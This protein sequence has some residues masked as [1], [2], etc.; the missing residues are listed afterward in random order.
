[1]FGAPNYA[2]E[3]FLV[4]YV[5]FFKFQVWNPELAYFGGLKT[6]SCT[7]SYDECRNTGRSHWLKTFRIRKFYF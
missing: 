4:Y 5:L 7:T 2:N 6:R 3:E 1:M